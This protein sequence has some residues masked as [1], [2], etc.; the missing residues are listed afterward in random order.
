M[1][2]VSKKLEAFFH[3][4][5]PRELW[6]YTSLEALDGILSSG[7]IWA[8]EARFTS[9]TTE[10]VFARQVAT[11][12]LKS[13]KPQMGDA[14]AGVDDLLK[15]LDISYEKGVLSPGFADVFIA[16]FSAAEDLK[17]QWIDYGKA[18]S[19][20]SIAFDLRN[21]RPPSDLDTS[22]T[23]APCI[24]Q[25]H[26]QEELIQEALN[27][28]LEPIY[29]LGK[30]DEEHNY[31]VRRLWPTVQHIWPDAG[32]PPYI[33]RA[34]TEIKEL[35]RQ[36]TENMNRDLFVLTSHCKNPKFFEEQEWRLV[37]PRSRKKDHPLIPIK[38]RRA[39]L[40]GTS[41]DIPYIEFGLQDQDTDRLPISGVITGPHCDGAEVEAILNRHDYDVPIT[42][43]QIPIR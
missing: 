8:T 16:S 42:P 37:L 7:K 14:Q 1:Y 23:L 29:V 10:Y 35:L 27:Q 5:I 40:R 43:S 2:R 26:K 17:S 21:A 22:T 41:I 13:L 12:Y 6:H 39:N 38:Y 18:Y 4:P 30:S 31:A 34:P 28:L 36:G 15:L 3:T 19:G 11:D 24:Y 32:E 25:K 33:R 20:V 9:D